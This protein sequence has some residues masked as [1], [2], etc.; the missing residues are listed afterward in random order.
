MPEANDLWNN[1][2]HHE[3]GKNYISLTSFS[4]TQ[5]PSEMFDDKEEKLN[6]TFNTN[7][8]SFG[9][10]ESQILHWLEPNTA[11][12]QTQ[13]L[14][15]IL[16]KPNQTW[17]F[18]FSFFF[19][20]SFSAP[21][22]NDNSKEPQRKTPKKQRKL[23]NTWSEGRES[24][25]EQAILHGWWVQWQRET[26]TPHRESEITLRVCSVSFGFHW[27]A[28]DPIETRKQE[29]ETTRTQRKIVIN[30]WF[31]YGGGKKVV[32]SLL[33]FRRGVDGRWIYRKRSQLHKQSR[34]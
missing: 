15:L 8:S 23:K 18:F 10:Q 5:T 29:V 25:G 26:Q 33:V 16:C 4:I 27:R 9:S 14:I 7:F 28:S 17:L 1:Q 31:L 2:W 3:K 20:Y 13:V 12:H 21:R 34:D 19:P 22:Q 24:R 11:E 6:K 30:L 32:V